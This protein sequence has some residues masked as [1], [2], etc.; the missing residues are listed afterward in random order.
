MT[1][2]Q[3]QVHQP[4]NDISAYLAQLDHTPLAPTPQ[5]T[6]S[7][8]VHWCINHIKQ[9]YAHGLSLDQMA[10]GAGLSKFHFLRKFRDEVGLTPCAF[11]KHYRLGKAM[12]RLAQSNRPIRA[13][14]EEVGYQDAAAFSRAFRKTVGTQP[15]KYRHTRQAPTRKAE[16][17]PSPP[18]TMNHR[19]T[20]TA[21]EIPLA[22]PQTNNY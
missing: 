6:P 10:E 20:K 13:I 16:A 2:T 3:E 4:P 17:Y 14:A 1:E 15:G 11:L 12:E 22:P 19:D 8:S 9:N 7:P 5:N 18:N 21:A